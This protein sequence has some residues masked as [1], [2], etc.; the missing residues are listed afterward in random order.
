MHLLNSKTNQIEIPKI[1]TLKEK[2]EEERANRESYV[3]KANKNGEVEEAQTM[4]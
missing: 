1:I 3:C 4:E 2:H